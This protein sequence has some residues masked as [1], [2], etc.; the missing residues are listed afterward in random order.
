MERVRARESVGR[1]SALGNEESWRKYD[2]A[3]KAAAANKYKVTTL[4]GKKGDTRPWFRVS[5]KKSEARR[6]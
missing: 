2:K 3:A 4:K 1:Q 6:T 5:G